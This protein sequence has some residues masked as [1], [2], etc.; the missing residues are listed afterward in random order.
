MYPV[1]SG[2]TAGARAVQTLP[3]P[4]PEAPLR[5]SSGAAATLRRRCRD[6][7]DRAV[8]EL[9]LA[10]FLDQGCSQV[11]GPAA[12]ALA[13]PSEVARARAADPSGWRL[14]GWKRPPQHDVGNPS[15]RRALSMSKEV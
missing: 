6:L 10:G 7:E 3:A 11:S 8:A 13:L 14:Q 15:K 4:E 9:F 2:S 5:A 1:I 12:D